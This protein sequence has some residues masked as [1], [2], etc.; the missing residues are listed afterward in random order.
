MAFAPLPRPGGGGGGRYPTARV[1]IDTS[2]A[3]G[4]DGVLWEHEVAEEDFFGGMS[5][6]FEL[7][8]VAD[9]QDTLV[10]PELR[11]HPFIGWAYGHH[12]SGQTSEAAR[13]MTNAAERYEV[14]LRWCVAASR[15]LPDVGDPARD[16]WTED[17]VAK[18]KLMESFA[19]VACESMHK[20]RWLMD[21]IN[22]LYRRGVEPSDA[23]GPTR[24]TISLRS[25]PCRC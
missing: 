8:A 9:D 17:M 21:N 11:E 12:N 1:P 3:L 5:D 24:G 13:A 19:M 15:S 16:L 23:H 4:R 25:A 6:M 18:F 10:P 2:M 7:F 20:A 14:K 22:R